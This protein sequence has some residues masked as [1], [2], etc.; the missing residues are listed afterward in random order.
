MNFSSNHQ[1]S[2]NDND[3]DIQPIISESKKIY[4]LV[5]PGATYLS[6]HFRYFS[7]PKNCSL[8]IRNRNNHVHEI[9]TGDGRRLGEFWAFHVLD[10][11]IFLE[12][13]CSNKMNK[14]HIDG[15]AAG[16]AD[17]TNHRRGKTVQQP[18]NTN[19]NLVICNKDEKRNAICWKEE[20]PEVY[21]KSRAVAKLLIQGT[22]V[23]TGW[24]VGPNN[25]LIANW[26]CIANEEQAL[27]TDY[28]FSY[29]A[30]RG[31]CQDGGIH[32]YVTPD[33]Y[34][35]FSAESLVKVDFE[36]DYALIKLMGDP[37]RKYG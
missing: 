12:S 24:L 18:E 35:T 19:R 17:M 15:Y 28:T 22:R 4:T 5:H 30:K 32:D 37:V 1:V 2:S 13:D 14:F 36:K 23:C 9:L 33:N 29:E 34:D 8:T 11:T 7:F 6:L 20:F 10:D 25:Y 27:N 21:E 31:S 3:S 26:H 16:F